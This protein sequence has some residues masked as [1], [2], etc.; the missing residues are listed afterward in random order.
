MEKLE[1]LEVEGAGIPND[2]C[3]MILMEIWQDS[4][5]NLMGV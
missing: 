1:K 3:S 4:I 5:G 2:F